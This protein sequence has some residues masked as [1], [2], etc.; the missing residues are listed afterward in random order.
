M[1]RRTG[2]AN[3]SLDRHA[4]VTLTDTL[5]DLRAETARQLY[6]DWR[7][8]Y[9]LRRLFMGAWQD[10]RTLE[11]DEAA[12]Y[13]TR[14]DEALEAKWEQTK[15]IMIEERTCNDCG[16]TWIDNGD[17]ACPFCCSMATDIVTD[18]NEDDD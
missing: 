7:G 4:V 10:V 5:A 13:R 2:R 11:R 14:A 16:E 8:C 17:E 12:V 6:D 1:G 18:E 3:R 15:E 9:V